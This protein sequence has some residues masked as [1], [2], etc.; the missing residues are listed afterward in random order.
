MRGRQTSGQPMEEDGAVYQTSRSARQGL[1][2]GRGPDNRPEAQMPGLF[3]LP[4]VPGK[5][6][7]GLQKPEI[8]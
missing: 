7:P 4:D 1:H 8:R 5:Q 2:T 3:S 6:V